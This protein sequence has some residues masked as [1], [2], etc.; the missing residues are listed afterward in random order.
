MW[1][2]GLQ[3]ENPHVEFCVGA[4]ARKGSALRNV[5]CTL[6]KKITNQSETSELMGKSYIKIRDAANVIYV[7]L[8]LYRTKVTF[9]VTQVKV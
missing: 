2:A 1:L 9:A 4:S 3:L 6:Q 5:V 7:Y 8:N